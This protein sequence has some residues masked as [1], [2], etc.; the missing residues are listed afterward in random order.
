[1]VFFRLEKEYKKK[2]QT[3]KPLILQG[4]RVCLNYKNQPQ[5][6]TLLGILLSFT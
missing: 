4:F 2:R 3:L 6:K 1:M 5:D